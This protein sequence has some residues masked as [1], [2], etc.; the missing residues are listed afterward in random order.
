MFKKKQHFIVISMKTNWKEMYRHR[1]SKRKKTITPN[2]K[3]FYF[4]N[5]RTNFLFTIKIHLNTVQITHVHADGAILPIS[6][7]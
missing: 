7:I 5:V 6:I 2:G 4:K 1:I 3:L